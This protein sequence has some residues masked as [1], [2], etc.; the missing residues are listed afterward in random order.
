M[1]DDTAPAVAQVSKKRSA[2]LIACCVVLGAVAAWA[3][4]TFC[5]DV[6]EYHWFWSACVAVLGS[7]GLFQ[8]ICGA[9][10]TLIQSSRFLRDLESQRDP[11]DTARSYV[12]RLGLRPDYDASGIAVNVAMLMVVP[13]IVIG[14]YHFPWRPDGTGLIVARIA[15]VIVLSFVVAFVVGFLFERPADRAIKR[16]KER[17]R[18][19][20]AE[21]F[22][23]FRDELR[24]IRRN[25]DRLTR[26]LINLKHDDTIAKSPARA[27]TWRAILYLACAE[28]EKIVRKVKQHYMITMDHALEPAWPALCNEAVKHIHQARSGGSDSETVPEA[29]AAEIQKRAE[30]AKSITLDQAKSLPGYREVEYQVTGGSPLMPAYIVVIQEWAVMVTSVTLSALDEFVSQLPDHTWLTQG[31]S[32]EKDEWDSERA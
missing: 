28:K 21:S 14:L 25:Q 7:A 5:R 31:T 3:G 24:A 2:G 30:S 12:E 32:A 23:H 18:T 27:E 29:L 6:L 16:V 9:I 26:F 11:R 13:L 4:F 19:T 17:I 15:A 22:Q 10:E 1:S 20:L 8:G